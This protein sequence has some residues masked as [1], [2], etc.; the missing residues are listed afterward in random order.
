[1]VKFICKNPECKNF[2]VEYNF[3]DG[4]D[5]AECGG[6]KATLDGEQVPDNPEIEIQ[7]TPSE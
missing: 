4:Y 7:L 5:T 1:M 6:C 3:A 2:E